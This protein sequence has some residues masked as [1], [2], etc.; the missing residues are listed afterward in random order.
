MLPLML[1]ALIVEGNLKNKTKGPLG[2]SVFWGIVYLALAIVA[3]FFLPSL[4]ENPFYS[5]I[6]KGF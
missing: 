3:L 4:P 1:I 6:L 5:I 2:I